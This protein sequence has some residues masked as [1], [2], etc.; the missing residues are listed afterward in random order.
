LSAG[1]LIIP[2]SG[3]GINAPK[4]KRLSASEATNAAALAL[5][6]DADALELGQKS[7]AAL[8]R[9]VDVARRL[10]GMTDED[11]EELEKN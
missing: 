5:F 2:T 8:V 11:V 3:R 10:S 9:V 1:T 4:V 6:A 7:A